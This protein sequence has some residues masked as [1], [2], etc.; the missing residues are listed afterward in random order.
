MF[1]IKSLTSIIDV[2]R[3]ECK[4]KRLHFRKEDTLKKIVDDPRLIY[5]CCY[6]YY[7]DG[8][9]Q[10]EICEQLGISRA[11]V[12]RLLKAGRDRNI[13]R[14]ELD[15]PDSVMYGELERKLESVF[16]LKEILIV[17]ELDIGNKYEH[18]K[19][20]NE[21][22]LSYFSRT[23]Q[24]QDYIGISMGH[25]LYDLA[26]TNYAVEDID[27]TF[28]PVVGGVG[29][30]QLSSQNYHSNE[31]AQSFAKKFNG[32]AVQFF[33]PAIFNDVAVMEGLMKERPVQEV[34]SLFSCL[35]AVI[36]GIGS[37]ESP[38]ST[39]VSSGYISQ[40]RYMHFKQQGAVGDA[41]LRFYDENGDTSK[42]EEFNNRVM[43]ISEQDLIHVENRIAVAVGEE[44]S[45]AVLGALRGRKIN[46]LITDISCVNK[47]LAMMED[48]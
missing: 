9:S 42:F 48:V 27:C 47:M 4:R 43:G 12:S 25:T 39:L 30:K 35:N 17:D 24:D 31:I 21:E 10:I 6:L 29:I 11:T 1:S 3:W 40:E 45:R 15:N 2:L 7:K 41:M 44:K 34:I 46:V 26:N 16:D 13:V 23:F 32:S 22:A 38:S 18:L 36:M 19:K 37:F 8:F 5:K 33:A 14:I 20:V 28:V